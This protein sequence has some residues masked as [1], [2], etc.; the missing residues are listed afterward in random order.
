MKKLFLLLTLAAATLTAAAQKQA[1]CHIEGTF[2][3]TP[4]D[5]VVHLLPFPG[6]SRS[7]PFTAIPV[8]D[9][10]FAY[11][12]RTDDIGAPFSLWARDD[13]RMGFWTTGVFLAV[14][15]T[16]HFTFDRPRRSPVMEARSADNR[17]LAAFRDTCNRRFNFRETFEGSYDFACSDT[18]HEPTPEENEQRRANILGQE[19]YET[20][21]IGRHTGLTGLYL[22]MDKMFKCK[23]NT[24]EPYAELYRTRYAHLFPENSMHTYIRAM[25]DVRKVRVGEQLPDL[26]APDAEGRMHSLREETRGRVAWVDFWASWCG[27][28]RR[29][30]RAMIPVY[31]A[32]KDRGFTVVGISRDK[33][34]KDMQT[35]A[36]KDGYPWL[37]LVL[38]GDDYHRWYSP[39]PQASGATYLVDRDGTIIAI[40]PTV[41]EVEAQL[42]KLLPQEPETSR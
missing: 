2:L 10:H 40:N 39:L 36:Q 11:D 27:P 33:D 14:D 24:P 30:S 23:E 1:T 42:G 7:H 35:A 41:E 38:L 6:D 17:E 20:D 28:C 21:Y 3:Y 5:T 8:K 12:F 37:N 25:L 31:E 32:W 13:E 22:I 26:N 29:V 4:H 18:P 9:G 34:V 16:L 15:D 19:A